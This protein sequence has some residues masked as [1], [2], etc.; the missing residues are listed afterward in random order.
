MD[1]LKGITR[2][3]RASDERTGTSDRSRTTAE[4]GR[5]RPERTADRDPASGSDGA[6]Q[7]AR[8]DDYLCPFCETTFDS[9]RGVCPECDA[10]IVMRGDR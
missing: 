4:A 6:D 9:D 8:A 5:N 1:L 2:E 3:L 10:E 7:R